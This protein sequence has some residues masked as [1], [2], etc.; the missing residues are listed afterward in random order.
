MHFKT[1]LCKSKT[2]RQTPIL[3]NKEFTHIFITSWHSAGI[4]MS[5][6]LLSIENLSK[7]G[8]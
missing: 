7:I 4:M 3:R 6:L 8:G 2:S 1:I 5:N